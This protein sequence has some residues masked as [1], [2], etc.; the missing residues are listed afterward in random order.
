MIWRPSHR[1]PLPTQMR[2]SGPAGAVARS[3]AGMS[4]NTRARARSATHSR[5]NLTMGRPSRS[6]SA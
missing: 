3:S 6:I 1:S 4:V 2:S 5:P